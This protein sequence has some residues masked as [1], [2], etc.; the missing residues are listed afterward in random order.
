M[1]NKESLIQN[2]RDFLKY[3][4]SGIVSGFI[5]LW[6]FLTQKHLDLTGLQGFQKINLS[7][8]PDGFYFFDSFIASKRGAAIKV[9]TNRCT[10]AGCKVNK[11]HNNTIVCACHG[12]AYNSSGEVLKGPASKNLKP[13][14][15]STNPVSGEITIKL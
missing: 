7:G 13:L 11:E 8:K 10:H 6:Y 3:L 14:P 5:V 15:F 1:A 9:F 2:R 4:G 12:S